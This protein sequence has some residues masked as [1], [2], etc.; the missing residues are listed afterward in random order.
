M[1]VERPESETEWAMRNRQL[2]EVSGEIRIA[3]PGVQVLFGFLLAVPFGSGFLEEADAFQEGVYLFALLTAGLSTALFIT[4]TAYHR[5]T[6]GL[7]EKARLVEIAARSAILGLIA[8][9]LSM[10]AC[11]LLVSSVILSH[12]AGIVIAG[13]GALMF[14]FLWFGL[15]LHRRRQLARDEDA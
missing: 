9:A 7:G 2:S 1:P 4:P 14:A 8:L 3:M 15:G 5:V 13:L 10:T 6:F 11:V 12:A